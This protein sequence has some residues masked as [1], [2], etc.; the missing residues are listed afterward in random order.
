MIVIANEGLRLTPR[1][2]PGEVSVEPLKPNLSA[3]A[4]GSPEPPVYVVSLVR[5]QARRV[6]IAGQLTASGTA[7]TF[8]DAIDAQLVSASWLSSHVDEQKTMLNTSRLLSPAE[9][10][11]ALSHR[12]IYQD[13]A[14]R[15]LVGAI[16]LEDD[17]VLA[18]GFS[19]M[20][21]YLGLM[22]TD[23]APQKVVVHL[24]AMSSPWARDFVV[25]RNS[26]VSVAPGL[27]IRDWVPDWSEE[28]WGTCGY[29]VTHAAA[30]SLLAEPRVHCVA[31]QWSLW[32]REQGGTIRLSVPGAVI[33]PPIDS[34]SLLADGRRRA[35]EFVEPGPLGR[36]RGRLAW[37]TL[38]ARARLMR[39]VVRPFARMFY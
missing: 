2:E 7:F 20:A 36:L 14:D 1:L 10:A 23:L 15:N 21:R 3:F 33:H 13:I 31:D 5:A 22:A 4:A 8:V 32:A 25:R 29:Y 37:I 6:S 27:T 26:V 9:I 38:R 35:I 16:V 11:C 30:V 17:V 28:P 12:S 19:A 34:A 39:H 18:P 24:A